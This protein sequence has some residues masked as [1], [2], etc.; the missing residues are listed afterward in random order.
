[1]GAPERLRKREDDHTEKSKRAEARGRGLPQVHQQ[2]HKEK[3]ANPTASEAGQI[4]REN[5][6]RVAGQLLGKEA[7]IRDRE[8]RFEGAL[9][10]MFRKDASGVFQQGISRRAKGI[11]AHMDISDDPWGHDRHKNYQS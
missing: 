1:M 6:L 7:H 5:L 11:S 9:K 10:A 3:S 8:L 4:V 2:P